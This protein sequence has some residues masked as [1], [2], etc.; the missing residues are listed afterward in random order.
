VGIRSPDDPDGLVGTLDVA[1]AAVATSGDYAQYFLYG[2]RRYHHL[3]D[4]ATGEPRQT[5]QHSVTV[6]AATCMAADAG[7]TAV[8]GMS[9]PEAD[10]LLARRGGRLEHVA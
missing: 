4:P 7:A 10:R 8:F 3:L 1:D 2:H 9:R 6:R 5:A